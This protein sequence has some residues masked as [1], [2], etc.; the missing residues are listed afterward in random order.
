MECS[1]QLLDE[2]VKVV[3]RVRI[4]EAILLYIGTIDVNCFTICQYVQRAL[5]PQ[6]IAKQHRTLVD[7]SS[8]I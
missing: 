2:A 5:T 6:T 4:I 7:M 8:D 1:V 3:D